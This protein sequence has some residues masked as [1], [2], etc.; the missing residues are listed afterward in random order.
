MEIKENP[1]ATAN[2][3]RKVMNENDSAATLLANIVH[4]DVT[5]ATVQDDEKLK[6]LDFKLD[7]KDVGIW[8]DPIGKLF[9][10]LKMA[11]LI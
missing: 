3:L 7:I 1:A 5:M 6:N 8:I 10:M 4:N 2:H 9:N 11:T